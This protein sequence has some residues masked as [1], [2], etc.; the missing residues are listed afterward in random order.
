MY[1]HIII[2]YCLLFPAIATAQFTTESTIITNTY[3]VSWSNASGKAFVAGNNGL[4]LRS[5]DNGASWKRTVLPIKT[6]I[7]TIDFA[8]Q[9]HGCFG[10]SAG[11]I[12][13]TDDGGTTFTTVIIEQN[14]TILSLALDAT[15]T[16]IAVSA[17][18]NVFITE[19]Y[20]KQ[21]LKEDSIATSSNFR[22]FKLRSGFGIAGNKG[23]VSL[24]DATTKKW[25]TI[26]IPVDPGSIASLI[27]ASGDMEA[28]VA[29][30][31][32]KAIIKG[33]PDGD[34]SRVYT[35][36]QIALN[37]WPLPDDSLLVLNDDACYC[38]YGDTV[39]KLSAPPGL[40]YYQ[41]VR[42]KTISRFGT[43]R[44]LITG[45]E[46]LIAT[47]QSDNN[48]WDMHSYIEES[49]Y[50]PMQRLLF[51]NDS[52]GYITGR[53]LFMLHTRNSGLTWR[54]NRFLRT[55][56]TLPGG[57]QSDFLSIS[58]SDE[59]NGSAIG[60]GVFTN[61]HQ[62]TT[63][64]RG[65]TLEQQNP[66]LL[67]LSKYPKILAVSPESYY[68]A[69]Y[70]TYNDTSKKAYY[71]RA[72]IYRT[73]NNGK[74]WNL[75]YYRADSAI[76]NALQRTSSGEILAMLYHN[77]IWDGSEGK[78]IKRGISMLR[79]P[80]DC[81][82]TLD[83]V[84]FPEPISPSAKF[85]M[86]NDSLGFVY[87]TVVGNTPDESTTVLYRTLNGGRTWEKLSFTAIMYGEIST[88]EFT[89]DG[90]LGLC[91][92]GT[93]TNGEHLLASSDKGATWHSIRTPVAWSISQIQS[94]G[95]S[96]F[97][98]L[99]NDAEGNSRLELLDVSVVNGIDDPPASTPLLAPVWLWLPYPNPADKLMNV[100]LQW[101]ASIS[102]ENTTF[103][104]YS[105]MGQK[106]ADLRY[107]LPKMS[108]LGDKL[109]VRWEV[110]EEISDGIY[111]LVAGIGG[112]K[113]VQPVAIFKR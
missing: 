37:V 84:Y 64:D 20:G 65:N 97:V 62:M 38:L 79:L 69:G 17:T 32:G 56:S 105:A 74:K 81:L 41:V 4:V 31:Y 29:L 51:V 3:A 46:S 49:N 48:T 104:L 70:R 55:D 50:R 22:V 103:A 36:S 92:V 1:R 39:I 16:G 113:R 21:W 102:A 27:S 9:L 109:T 42:P 82:T 28:G 108:K 40:L 52:V 90:T 71:S 53:G 73:D 68:L 11:I 93:T 59:T 100:E 44:W 14:V 33:T 87:G 60:E 15:G 25:N 35:H 94:V 18:G 43:G 61:T 77:P 67:P 83:S 88:L 99:E 107:L 78:F 98:V 13:V 76:F 24:R 57:D 8:D 26:Q 5:N 7:T 10:S 80:D 96:S 58:F 34:F 86:A 66:Y 23:F 75:I 2:L 54:P 91:S 85:T 106:I 111:Y 6:P 30:N 89:G 95:G 45:D 19:N 47:I 72:A 110:P 101:G 112:Y 63:K 12:C